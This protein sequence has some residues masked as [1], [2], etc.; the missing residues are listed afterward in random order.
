MQNQL[1]DLN[2]NIL[3]EAFQLL[4]NGKSISEVQLE[5]ADRVDAKVKNIFLNRINF[6]V[7][8]VFRERYNMF[9]N[10]LVL[11]F[12]LVLFIMTY[13]RVLVYFEN[14]EAFTMIYKVLNILLFLFF[15]NAAWKLFKW[16]G[17][18][19]RS[20]LVLM[21]IFS[22]GDLFAFSTNLTNLTFITRFV[23]QLATGALAYYLYRNIFPTHGFMGA[24]KESIKQRDILD[25]F[26]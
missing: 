13:L 21:V 25:D 1:K 8:N 12:L 20:I 11:L 22:I 2:E 16:E 24:P 17:S 7:K 5:M 18:Y 26:R 14:P 10:V 15:L 4:E 3:P 23:L 19:L 6:Y 9:K